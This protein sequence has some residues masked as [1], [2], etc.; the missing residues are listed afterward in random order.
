MYKFTKYFTLVMEPKA[1]IF[2]FKFLEFGKNKLLNN[3]SEDVAFSTNIGP[4]K[5]KQKKLPYG[6]RL[7]MN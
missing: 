5:N 3:S 2:R 7:E 4:L 1:T 6:K